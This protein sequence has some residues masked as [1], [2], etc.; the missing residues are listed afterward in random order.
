MRCR[1]AIAVFWLCLVALPVFADAQQP[2]S[3]SAQPS[4]PASPIVQAPQPLR[5]FLDCGRCDL[6]YVRQNVEFV[7]YVRDRAVADLQVLV[8]S[9]PTGGGGQS[10]NVRFI[11]L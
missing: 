6:E 4:S 10:W 7:D 3:S 2:S 8:T 1:A 5:V 11:G 9:Q